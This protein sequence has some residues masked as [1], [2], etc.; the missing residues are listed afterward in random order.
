MWRIRNREGSRRFS[1]IRHPAGGWNSPQGAVYVMTLCTKQT[2]Y[3]YG[4]SG[5]TPIEPWSQMEDYSWRDTA[6]HEKRTCGVIRKIDPWECVSLTPGSLEPVC[7]NG[8]V[9]VLV[10]DAESKF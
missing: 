2:E 7:G 1:D 5:S 10:A 4:P 8:T 6:G 9:D 3:Q